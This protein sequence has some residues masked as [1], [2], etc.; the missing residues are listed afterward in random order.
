MEKVKT[1]DGTFAYRKDCRFIK[2]SYYKK[3]TQCFLINDQWYRINSGYIVFDHEVNTW[4]LKSTDILHGIINI[5]D[6]SNP[7]FGYFSPNSDKNLF[8]LHNNV[9]ECVLNVDALSNYPNI[10]EGM[11]GY[12]YYDSKP[13]YPIPKEFTTKL[14]PRKDGFYTFPFNYGSEPLI[15]EFSNHFKK[16]FEG[17]PLLSDAYKYL[18]GYTFGVEFETES[19]AI[20]ERYLRKNGLIACRDGSISGFEYTTVPLQG[21]T[22][23]Q[24]I[25]A[26]CDLLKRFCK[27]SINESTH[28][29]IGGYPR[30]IKSIVAL[31]RLGLLIEKQIYAMFPYYY[32][33]TSKFK[34][35]SYCGPL[36]RL[37][38]EK[39]TPNTIFADM[40][41][42]L[43]NGVVFNKT[44]PTG[45]HPL[46]RSG[47]HKWEISPRYVWENIIPLIWGTRKTVEFRCH[48]PTVKSQKVIN[49]LF[50]LVAIL[51]YAKKNTKE[52]VNCPFDSLKSIDLYDIVN[53]VYPKKVSRILNKYI[54]DRITYYRNKRDQVGENEILS[55]EDNKE[56]FNLISFI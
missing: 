35:K 9:I 19:G 52:L 2:G 7:E 4:V 49:W 12:Y 22:G 15:P 3:N 25:K 30:N 31:Y 54:E 38:M 41:Y 14:K 23:I 33:N 10:K 5:V 39:S 47:Q 44:L 28:I 17:Y 36:P 24:A 48:T 42:W 32:A 53:E 11:N 56:V 43:S 51:K 8:Y 20:P 29:H 46:D 37:G 27:C 50:I 21:E 1:F 6:I 45:Q 40:F 18:D 16:H 26:N 55:E 13:G 34:K